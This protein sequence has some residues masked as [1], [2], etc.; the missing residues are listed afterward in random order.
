MVTICFL[1]TLTVE[2]DSGISKPPNFGARLTL[3]RLKNCS[4]KAV[5]LNC[6]I[7]SESFKRVVDT[8]KASTRQQ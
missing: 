5:G 4:L 2:S 6:E 7:N 8:A 1:F 3:R